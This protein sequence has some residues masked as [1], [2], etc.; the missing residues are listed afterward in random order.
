MN[1]ALLSLN[2]INTYLLFRQSKFDETLSLMK[3]IFV[4]IEFLNKDSSLY[5]Y[6]KAD[7]LHFFFKLALTS[8]F[9]RHFKN[10]EF[11]IVY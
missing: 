2:F 6:M 7:V 10:G 8:P 11:L 1:F 4:T 5:M 9:K 3:S